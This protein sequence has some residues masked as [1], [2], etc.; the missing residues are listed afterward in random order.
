MCDSQFGIFTAPKKQIFF[1][2]RSLKREHVIIKWILKVTH[3]D[4]DSSI[5]FA[6]WI[7]DGKVLTQ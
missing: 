2:Q 6:D 1:P 7:K 5:D 3:K 4:K